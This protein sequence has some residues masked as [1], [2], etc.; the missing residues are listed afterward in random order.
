VLITVLGEMTYPDQ[1]VWTTTLLEVLRGLGVEDHASRQAISRSAAAGWIES[2]RKGRAVRWRLAPPG[3]EVVE[4]GI[5]RRDAFLE[6]STPW[7]GNWLALLISVPQEQRT[8]RRQLYGGLSWLGLG[9]PTAGVW[10]T[11]HT[12]AA[13]G[14]RTL[15]DS[16]DLKATALAFVGSTRDVGMTDEEIVAHSWDLTDL[17]QRYAALLER[18]GDARPASGEELM[19]AHLA[20]LNLLQRFMRIDPKLP[21]ELLPEWIGREAAELFRQRRRQWTGPALAHWGTLTSGQ[22]KG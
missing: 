22:A 3:R 19:L 21:E 9:N 20:L 16:F 4:D 8:I 17:G 10:V 6:R 14:V 2:E 18:Y 1:P 13:A 12:D 11:P 15:V 5:R 7:D